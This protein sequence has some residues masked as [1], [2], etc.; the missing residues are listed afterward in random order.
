MFFPGGDIHPWSPAALGAGNRLVAH[1]SLWSCCR[2]LSGRVSHLNLTFTGSG[3]DLSST[4]DTLTVG[5]CWPVTQDVDV[6]TT[7]RYEQFS[8][9]I[10][11]HEGPTSVQIAMLETRVVLDLAGGGPTIAF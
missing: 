10:L 5:P 8:G 7:M 9:C 4:G 6:A 2:R 1:P 11:D 3:V